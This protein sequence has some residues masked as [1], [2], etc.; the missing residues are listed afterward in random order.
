MFRLLRSVW[1]RRTFPVLFLGHGGP[2][3]PVARAARSRRCRPQIDALEDRLTPA[4]FF[5]TNTN[6]SGAGSLRQAILDANAFSG[7]TIKFNL[8]GTGVQTISPP[9]GDLPAITK[10]VLIDGTTQPGFA[11]QP[12]IEIE[13]SSAGLASGLELDAGSSG[14]VIR[15]LI[16]NR[17]QLSAIDIFE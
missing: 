12:L 3:G 11:G 6:A 2:R 13:G 5:V 9:S 17:F 10:P 4:T 16:I 15:G 8:P 7:G 1:L 14:S